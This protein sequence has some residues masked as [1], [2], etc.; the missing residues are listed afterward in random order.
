MFEQALVLFP[1]GSP[2]RWEI[3]AD[4]LQKSSGE[5]KEHYEALVHDVIEIESG[6]V[7]VP[8]YIDDSAGWDT[9]GQVTFGCK[10]GENER[11]RGTPWSESEHKY[12]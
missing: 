12:V 3:I 4:Q 2:N 5:V 8:Y 7:H 11:K 1:E 10:H 6:R 9:A